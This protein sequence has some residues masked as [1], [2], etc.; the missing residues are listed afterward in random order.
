[1][2][3]SLRGRM[4]LSSV[5]LLLVVLVILGFILAG[6]ARQEASDALEERLTLAGRALAGGLGPLLD[7]PD[8]AAGLG[9]LAQGAQAPGTEVVILGTDG[10]VLYTSGTTSVVSIKAP[11]VREAL[12]GR[13]GK[14]VRSNPETGSSELNLAVPILL[15]GSVVGVVE[16]VAS[17]RELGEAV[18]GVVVPIVILGAVGTGVAIALVFAL[19][20]PLA[21]SLRRVSAVARRLASGYLYERVEQPGTLEAEELAEAINQ[22]ASGLEQRVR[23]S[24]EQRDTLGA[25]IDTMA[26]AL[27]VTDEHGVVSLVNPAALQLFGATPAE[28][29]GRSFIEI[30]R[31]HEMEDVL[32]KTLAT[33]HSQSGEVDFGPD[34]RMLRVVATPIEQRD[35][36]S[37]LVIVQDL[38]T[39][40]RL[41]GM[42]REFVANVSHEL[43]TPLASIKAAVEAL[44]GGAA[45]DKALAGEFLER[46]N[47]EVDELT[48]L[49]QRL[50]DLSRVETGKAALEIN[51]LDIREV[52]GEV[53]ERLRPLAEQQGLSIQTD[54][55]PRL[56]KAMAD[57]A[58]V[59][60][61]LVNLLGNAI[62]FT[63][64]GG[65]I[66]LSARLSEEEEMVEIAVQ[67]TGEG[68]HPDHLPH[69]FE[70][71]YKADRSRSS[72]GVGLGL[73]IAKH[74]VQAQGGRIWAESIL[75][76][77]T[78]FHI[79]LP[80]AAR[81]R[82][83]LTP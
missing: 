8:P 46:V 80:G 21:A 10:S 16:V 3:R 25:V 51:P 59:S 73:A 65:S 4:L 63:P 22:M 71:F 43:R 77:G 11:E 74:L 64:G 49:V 42:R 24:F 7:Q 67:D 31:D 19:T 56:A 28:V 12:A 41:E 75:E 52:I 13:T 68:I 27:L 50:M 44:Q 33:G 82:R 79:T 48:Q 78:V 32:H 54:Y 6:R 76:K 83:R 23:D 5:S 35:R 55:P 26:D 38:T 47:N 18:E 81:A 62:K 58:S 40:Q 70:R 29:M 69:I 20:M 45:E 14:D 61:V 72:D 17:R 39:V 37:V 1:M 15:D 66:Q 34:L 2:I 53:A 60:E 9:P 30:V 57:R 36:P